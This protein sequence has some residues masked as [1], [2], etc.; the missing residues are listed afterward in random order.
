LKEPLFINIYAQIKA[1]KVAGMEFFGEECI[2]NAVVLVFWWLL[3]TM[4]SDCFNTA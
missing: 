1:I 3:S 4:A 2:N